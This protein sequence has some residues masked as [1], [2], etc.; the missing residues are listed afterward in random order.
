MG[1]YPLMVYPSLAVQIGLNEALVLQKIHFWTNDG[2]GK[3]KDGHIWVYNSYKQWKTDNFPFWHER[4]IQRIIENLEE[5][6]LLI[7]DNFN[8]KSTDRTKWY[9]INYDKLDELEKKLEAEEQQ[10]DAIRQNVEKHNEAVKITF[11]N[12]TK[13]TLTIDAC[14]DEVAALVRNIGV[15]KK[16]HQNE[17]I[18][19]KFAL[20]DKEKEMITKQAKTHTPNDRT[21][22]SIA[23]NDPLLYSLWSLTTN[24]AKYKNL[25]Q[26]HH[27][28]TVRSSLVKVII[29]FIKQYNRL[30]NAEEL[31]LFEEFLVLH[32]PSLIGRA[33]GLAISKGERLVSKLKPYIDEIIEKDNQI[34]RGKYAEKY[35]QYQKKQEQKQNVRVFE[36]ETD[37]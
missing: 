37:F 29:L 19:R 34:K 36:H 26:L 2:R 22:E 6:D 8:K 12:S 18:V 5:N 7:S 33:F 28:K 15:S 31:Q 10:N 13:Y 1:E 20:T 4:T 17:Q 14:M 32:Q 9:R 27:L 11:K 24:K 21:I 23:K 16:D 3:E 30:P 35:G 25:Y